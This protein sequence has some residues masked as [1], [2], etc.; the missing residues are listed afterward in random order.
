[1][2]NA[3]KAKKYGIEEHKLK[4]STPDELAGM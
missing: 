4:N 1:L 2:S 3:K